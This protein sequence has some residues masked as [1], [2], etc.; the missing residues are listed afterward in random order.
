MKGRV[1]VK[2]MEPAEGLAMPE[3]DRP[4]EKFVVEDLN[5]P[6]SSSQE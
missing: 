1:E 4:L 2:D 5:C 6:V 3:V